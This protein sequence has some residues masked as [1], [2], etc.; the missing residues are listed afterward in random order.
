MQK[1]KLIK[2]IAAEL[3]IDL[4]RITDGGELK[5]TR[6][7]LEKRRKTEFWPQ[8]FANQN[9]EELTKPALHFS[10][11]KSI[12]V[13]AFNYN[14]N[15]N[16]SLISNYVT[17]KDYH[18]YVKEKLEKLVTEMQKKI[19]VDFNYKIF[20][21]KA[22]FL[23]KA[24]AQ[25]AGIG[26][27]GK[28]TLLINPNLGSNLFLGEIFLDIEIKKDEPLALDCGD[29]SLCIDNCKT[30][31]L[32]EDH[33]L[34]AADCTAY[35]TQKKGILTE[36]EI[37]KIGGHI[38]GC[39]DCKDICPYNKNKKKTKAEEMQFFN[40]DLE[41]FLSIERKNPPLELK[42]TAIMW[43]GTRILIRNALIVAA[44]LKKEKYYDLIKEKL[45]DNSPV[46]RYYALYALA[47]IDFKRAE[48]ILKKQIKIETNKE[49]KEEMKKVLKLG[50]D[51]NGH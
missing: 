45:K 34:A 43:R 31:A 41:Y 50:E 33:L 8:P 51:K 38:W 21:D 35:L 3:D 30:E 12:I 6:K 49:Y 46:I 27:I 5:K 25:K 42:D 48:D 18:R 36:E 24:L 44:N 4:C 20:V 19:T 1:N 28:N 17:V 14:N 10:N 9:L 37:K 16:S 22:P 2:E 26:F 40:S 15:G 7:I 11:L 13:A 23:E 39:D 32:K 29:C 47:K